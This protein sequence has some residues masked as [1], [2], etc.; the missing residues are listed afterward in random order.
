MYVEPGELT[1]LAYK[2]K[3]QSAELESFLSFTVRKKSG[4]LKKF[5]VEDNSREVFINYI[6]RRA[7]LFLLL[8]VNR[9]YSSVANS[10]KYRAIV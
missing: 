8:A 5:Y 6:L 3:L 4:V 10:S 2:R 7:S 9:L 1:H